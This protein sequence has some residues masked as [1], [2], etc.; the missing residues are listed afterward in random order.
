MEKDDKILRDYSSAD[1]H[2]FKKQLLR[3]N[4]IFS[5]TNLHKSI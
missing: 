2:K 5:A 1:T 4:K 3:T